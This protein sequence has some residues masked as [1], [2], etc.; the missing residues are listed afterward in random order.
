MAVNQKKPL[1][2]GEIAL[3]VRGLIIGK[4]LT[5]IV[6]GGL[7]WWLLKPRIFTSTSANSPS[8]QTSNTATENTSTFKTI[9]S[10]P[11]GSFNYGGSTAWAPLRLYKKT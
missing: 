9:A 3:F 10:V 5:I 7:F 1:I 8:G 11:S 4:V 6:I 2:N